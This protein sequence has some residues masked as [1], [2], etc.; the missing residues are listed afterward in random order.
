M[1]GGRAAA[2]LHQARTAARRAERRV[3]PLCRE[4][5]CDGVVGRY[6]NRLSDFLYT[7]ARFA[8]LAA[9]APETT[10]CKARE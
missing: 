2:F 8:A 4:G 5:D 10:Y 3:V 1:C 7:A 6:L 9:G